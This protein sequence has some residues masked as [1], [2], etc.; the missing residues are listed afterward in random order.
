MSKE[1]CIKKAKELREKA[2][3][4]DQIKYHGAATYFLAAGE[5]EEAKKDILAFHVK[6]GHIYAPVFNP[7]T[8]L[9]ID[10]HMEDL[11]AILF[12]E[13]NFKD[14]KIPGRYRD[15]VSTYVKIMDATAAAAKELASK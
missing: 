11:R 12:K 4:G 14:T 1:D 9:I 15:I 2:R 5:F 7:I 8:D 13:K 6:Q 10:G 3:K